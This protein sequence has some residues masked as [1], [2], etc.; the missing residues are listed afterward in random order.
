MS[1]LASLFGNAS[2]PAPQ[3]QPNQGQSNQG[4]Q[5]QNQ[6][7]GQNN[8]GGQSNP[9]DNSANP[10]A[11]AQ[12]AGSNGPAD[13]AQ[14]YAKMWDNST[15]KTNEPPKLQIDDKVLSQVTEKLDFMQGVNPELM[16]KAISGDMNALIELLQH[17][18]RQIYATTLKHNAAVTDAYVGQRD[19]FNSSNLPSSI[20]R[21]LTLDTMF[22]GLKNIPEFAKQQLK[23]TALRFQQANPDASPA[24]VQQAVQ[25]YMRQVAG[26]VNPPSSADSNNDQPGSVDWDKWASS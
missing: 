10:A 8:Q 26:F 11:P 9:A 1:F 20:K 25:D 7:Q 23:D 6:Q 16:Q 14:L 4:Q 22:S 3:P 15:N 18:G 24:E 13:P 12:N 5:Q 19:Q 17:Q 2:A 21:E